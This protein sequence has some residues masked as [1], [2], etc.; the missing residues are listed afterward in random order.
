MLFRSEL[1]DIKK[2]AVRLIK[3]LDLMV[4]MYGDWALQRKVRLAD[5]TKSELQIL[6]AGY[7]QMLPFR[8]RSGRR[9]MCIVG[10]LGSE[11][12]AVMRVS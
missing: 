2:A 12:D 1:F 10:N 4:E 3:Y 7:Y 9:I 5:F 6:K 8:D 11:F